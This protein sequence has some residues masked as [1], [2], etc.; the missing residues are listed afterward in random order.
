MLGAIAGD[1]IGSLYEI[2]GLKTMDFP[3]FVPESRFT[4]DTVLTMAVADALLDSGRYAEKIHSYGN[5][6]PLAGYGK[7]FRDWLQSTDLQPYNSWGN[8]SAMRVSPVS[9]VYGSLDEVLQE[10]EKSAVVTHNHP[11]GV[12]GAQAIA[13]AVFLARKRSSKQEI[14]EYVQNTFGYNLE[15]SIEQIRPDYKFD[16]SCQGSVPESIIAFL[17]STD[18]ENAIR[19]AISLGGDTDTMACMAG[20]IAEPFYGG[21]PK[22]IEIEV[23][24][25]LTADLLQTMDAFLTQ[26]PTK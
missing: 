4:D 21:L 10:A 26:F 22:E 8:G 5:K 17:E 7:S 19:L 3:L 2:R 9:Y 14:K 6:Y 25:R 12:K 20:S 23:R 13:A 11:E 16:V 24:K 1:I 15:R 18:V